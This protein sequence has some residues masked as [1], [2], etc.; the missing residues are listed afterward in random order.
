MRSQQR[1]LV[2]HELNRRGFLGSAFGGAVSTLGLGLPS[3]C[4]AE[5]ASPDQGAA[6]NRPDTLFLTWQ[7]DPTTTMTVQWIASAE[8]A[9]APA[10]AY[11]RHRQN[12]WREVETRA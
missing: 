5:G 7:H 1:R 4:K 6:L 9:K 3:W 11:S 8:G 2:M 10:I 12:D